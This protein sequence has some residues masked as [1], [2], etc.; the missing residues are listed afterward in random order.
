M[1]WMLRRGVPATILALA[2]SVPA[3]AQATEADPDLEWRREMEAR[4]QSVMEENQRM[5]NEIDELRA[6][7]N[8]D[9]LTEARAE[10]IRALVNDVLAD[11]DSRTSL[12]QNGMTAGWNEHFFLAS[13]DGRFKLQVDGQMQFRWIYNFHDAADRHRHGFEITRTKLTFRGHVFNPDLTYLLRTDATR[14]EPELVTGL[15]FVRD[16][17]LRY[18]LNNQ[19]SVRFGQFKLPF[20]REELVPSQYQLAVERSTVNENSNIGRSQ[21]VELTY[22]DDINKLMLMV[23]DGA[24]DNIGGFGVAGNLNPVNSNALNEDVEWAVT[25][26]YERLLAGNWGQFDDF[27][28]PMDEE[29]AA[30][31]GLG[32]HHQATEFT[33]GQGGSRNEIYWFTSTMDLSMEWGGANA[34]ASGFYHYVDAST[35]NLSVFAV[36]L[37]AG[38][39]FTPKLEAYARWEYGWYETDAARF[40]DLNMLTL[41]VNYYLDGHDLKWTTDIGFGAGRVD[42]PWDSDI[43][44]WRQ[45]IADAEPQIVFRTQFQLLF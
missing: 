38:A 41:G 44:G 31:W 2:I 39:Y 11:S 40:A 23:S 16:A 33:G 14:N 17:W 30:L 9:W 18:R 24:T 4:L 36:A 25:G 1:H 43:A 42:Q 6:A 10:E 26:R 19:W 45:D 21:G 29:F 27:T 12:L 5:R 3:L 13:P 32:V 20:N 15:Y 7:D 35:F 8:E 37:Q 34:F 22:A 28:S